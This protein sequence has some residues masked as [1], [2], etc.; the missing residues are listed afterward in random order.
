TRDRREQP[1]AALLLRLACLDHQKQDLS[2]LIELFEHA[3]PALVRGA[4]HAVHQLL[5]PAECTNARSLAIVDPPPFESRAQVQAL[6]QRLSEAHALHDATRYD[7]AIGIARAVVT[8]ARRLDYGPLLAEALF[9][10][11]DAQVDLDA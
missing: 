6:R 3:D 11:G 10:L 1:E 8:E 2:A 4:P 7:K 5:G 9:A